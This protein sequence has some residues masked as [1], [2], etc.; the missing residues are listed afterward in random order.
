MNILKF[1]LHPGFVPKRSRQLISISVQ[2]NGN[3]QGH[4]LFKRPGAWPLTLRSLAGGPNGALSRDAYRA[5][6]HA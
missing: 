3:E 4:Y 1:G 2:I 5:T 6:S